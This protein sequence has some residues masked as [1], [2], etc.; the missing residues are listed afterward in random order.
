MRQA[1]AARRAASCCARRS[2]ARMSPVM[3]LPMSAA[4]QRA[5]ESRIR[6]HLSACRCRRR[7]ARRERYDEAQ[8]RERVNQRASAAVRMR[9]AVLC[10]NRAACGGAE[11]SMSWQK[12]TAR[13]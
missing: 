1:A 6:A 8:Q 9:A 7:Y 4:R 10:A 13:T 2:A 12:R 11:Y 5:L 3:Q